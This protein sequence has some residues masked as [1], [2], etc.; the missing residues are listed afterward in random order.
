MK[1]VYKMANK[2]SKIERKKYSDAMRHI[3]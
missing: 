1:E 3:G 2:C